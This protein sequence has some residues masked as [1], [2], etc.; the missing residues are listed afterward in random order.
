MIFPLFS[1]LETAYKDNKYRSEIRSDDSRQHEDILYRIV[2]KYVRSCKYSLKKDKLYNLRNYENI[3]SG[4]GSDSFVSRYTE[5]RD[6][7]I[8]NSHPL[9]ICNTFFA[10][11]EDYIDIDGDHLSVFPILYNVDR[12][13]DDSLDRIYNLDRRSDREYPRIECYGKKFVMITSRSRGS[14]FS[15]II[16]LLSPDEILSIYLAII[17]ILTGIEDGNISNILRFTHYDL[18]TENVIIDLDVRRIYSVFLDGQIFQVETYSISIIDLG[19]SYLRVYHDGNEIE[20]YEDYSNLSNLYGIYHPITDF[21]KITVHTLLDIQSR[22]EDNESIEDERLKSLYNIIRD[23][24]LEIM[25]INPGIYMYAMPSISEKSIKVRFSDIVRKIISVFIQSNN[26]I[27]DVL[28]F[29][30]I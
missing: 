24:Y 28:M 18:H 9:E 10:G 8:K 6:E 3:K 15:K 17:I 23:V 29:R 25:G 30:D 4:H 19:M 26:S 16:R 7:I 12:C 1:D 11:L 13:S 20:L 2:M 22:I 14:T 27:R 21:N 5:S